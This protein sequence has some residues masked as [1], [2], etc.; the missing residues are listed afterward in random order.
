MYFESEGVREFSE[1]RVFSFELGDGLR[2][3]KR[4]FPFILADA[5]D[6]WVASSMGKIQNCKLFMKY[7]VKRI[8]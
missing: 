6:R 3:S 4:L 1:F 2:P 7:F 8:S 5:V